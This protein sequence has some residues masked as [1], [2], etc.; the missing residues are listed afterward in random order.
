MIA[1]SGI[2][3]GQMPAPSQAA[4]KTSAAT[5]ANSPTQPPAIPDSKPSDDSFVIGNDDVLAINVWKE[6]DFSSPSTQV[7][8]D[9]KISLPLVG[10]VPAAG[11][12]PL[13]LEEDLAA[14]LRNYITKP[15]VTVMVEQINS[16]KFN[17]LGQVVKPGSYSLALAP[18]IVDAIAIAGGP[19]DFAKQKSIYILRENLGGTQ[20]RIMFNYKD[21]LK[22]KNQNIKLEP[23]DTVV[24]P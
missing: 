17:I 19:R 13:Q 24:V 2:A 23:R 20:T 14:K 21:F 4:R 18:T 3:V 15:Q 10:E 16:K 8:S 7:R 12:T 5:T 6:P 22:G 9:G 11:L 1:I